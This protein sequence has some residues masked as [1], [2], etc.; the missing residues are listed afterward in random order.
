MA[1][2]LTRLTEIINA[3]G[4]SYRLTYDRAGQL[5][6]ETDFTGRTLTYRY[7]AAGRCIRTTFPDG[8]H[9][10]RRYNV[11][12]QVTDED[13]TQGDSD[14]ILSTTTFRYDNT[15]CR[16]VEAKNNDATVT[17][18]YDDAGRITAEPLTADARNTA[19][20]INWIRWR[21]VPPAKSQSSSPV[22]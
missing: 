2:D 18:E 13:V 15:L 5:I 3:E 7:D 19:P 22:T 10:H 11:T 16:L 6:A 1:D 9:L 8:T 21:N 20:T 17:C 4:E 14:R 12:N